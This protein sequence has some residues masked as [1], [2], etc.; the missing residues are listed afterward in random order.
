MKG[1]TKFWLFTA[2]AAASLS[3]HGCGGKAPF[4]PPAAAADKAPAKVDNRVK[5]S[6]LTKVTLS[7]EA[8]KR[9]GIEVAEAM[10]TEVSGES[11]IAGEVML[12]PG[13]SLTATAPVAGKVHLSRSGLA[14]GQSVRRGEAVF[15]ITPVLGPQRDLRTTYEQEVQQAK[16]RLEAAEQQLNR[17]RQLL[18]DMAGSQK[19]VEIAA[20]E[21]GQ[22]KAVY[23]A[24]VQRLERLKSHPLEADVDMEIPAPE[25]GVVRQLLA[26]EDQ[27]VAAGAPLIEVADLSRVWLRVP[28]YAGEV[29]SISRLSTIRVRDVDGGGPVRQGVRVTAPPT[30]DPVAATADVY[31][32]LRNPDL[33]LRPGQRMTVPLP[34][35]D[36][37]RKGV[38]VP[39]AALLYDIHG[40]AWVYVATAPQHYQRQRVEFLHTRGT[41]AI[42][43]RG[44]APGTKVVTAG[45][46]ELFGTEFGAGK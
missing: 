45:A 13:K 28:V 35:P 27:T 4:T 1:M 42:L 2:A 31:F 20:Q 23:D 22:A 37:G 43:G 19:N 5:E 44:L 25:T 15:R 10:P 39:S 9:L 3:L 18:R 29:D 7:P 30:A 36:S 11:A 12:I 34:A 8:E 21:F 38:S 16:V 24:A 26:S 46:A 32:E 6:D 14:V 17:T 40:G 41:S 33:Q